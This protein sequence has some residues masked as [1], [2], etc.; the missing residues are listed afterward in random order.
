MLPGPEV[1]S[2][3]IIRTLSYF[4]CILGAPPHPHPLHLAAAPHPLPLAAA[5]P[6]CTPLAAAPKHSPPQAAAAT[7]A[8]PNDTP[9]LLLAARLQ[10]G[11]GSLIW[12]SMT[13]SIKRKTSSEKRNIAKLSQCHNTFYFSSVLR[14]HFFSL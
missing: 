9:P 1:D 11:T 4:D 6:S 7:A 2:G 12:S 3:I 10:V 5:A 13:M 14:H 8:P